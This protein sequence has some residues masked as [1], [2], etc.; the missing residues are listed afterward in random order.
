M[1]AYS[2]ASPPALK[3]QIEIMVRK[4]P[5]GICSTWIHDHVKE[6][7]KIWFSGPFGQFHLSDSDLP[8]IF[9]GGGSGMAP[10]WSMLRYMQKTGS[11]RKTVYFFGAR[12]QQDLFLVN[13]LK[14]LEK[15]T[16]WFTFIP[17]LSD[18][19]PDT[20]WTGERGL[21]TEVVKRY[22]PSASGFEAY[23]CGAP[24]M[25]D[26]SIKILT[27]AGMPEKNIFFDKF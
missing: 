13:D 22:Y 2:L 26:A 6:G 18:E 7:D 25:I 14:E 19:R 5:S 9:I 3:K 10:F 12:T 24:G 20:G 8:M 17:A 21:I 11:R 16:D 4:V 15:Q 1:R 23:L 27:E